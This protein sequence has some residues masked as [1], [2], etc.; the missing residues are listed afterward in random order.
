M[1]GL[2]NDMELPQPPEPYKAMTEQPDWAVRAAEAL[3]VTGLLARY[4]EC[5][6]DSPEEVEAKAAAIIRANSPDVG[7]LKVYPYPI[8]DGPSVPW[9]VMEP[10]EAMA[11][12]NHC[13]S[14]TRLAER[15]GLSCGE[16]WCVVNGIEFGHQTKEDWELWKR[17]WFKFAERIAL[18]SVP[19]PTPAFTSDEDGTALAYAAES[20]PAETLT[21]EFA[22]ALDGC[23][24]CLPYIHE[25]ND[26]IEAAKAAAHKILARYK[27]MKGKQ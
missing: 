9:F 6:C 24:S 12:K 4:D 2:D 27:A 16:A 23:L 10:H 18:A 17:E 8:M 1:S 20:I 3:S 7:K 5:Q 22:T 25:S 15:G 19:Q 21:D 14:L 11:R 13:Q 26:A